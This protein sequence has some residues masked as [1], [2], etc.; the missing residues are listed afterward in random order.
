VGLLA[1]AL[2]EE[3]AP[4]LA[5]LI[6]GGV[7]LFAGGLLLATGRNRLKSRNLKPSRL[8]RS[9]RRDAEVVKEHIT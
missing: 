7:V 5:P 4:W 8:A 3:Q 1:L 2:P 9:V 6:V